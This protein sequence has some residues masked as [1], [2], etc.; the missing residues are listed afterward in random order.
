V[1]E[2]RFDVTAI[3][4]ALVDVIAEVDDAWVALHGLEKGTMLLVDPEAAER[5][6]GDLPPAIESSGGSAANTVAGIASLGGRAAYIGKVGDDQLG[7]V[8]AH[9]LRAA[10]VAFDVP[11]LASGPPTGRSLIAVTPDAQRTMQTLLGAAVE[12]GPEDVDETLIA[13]SAVTYLEGYLWDP[14]RAKEAFLKAARVAHHAGRR[15]A[16]TLSDRFC[17]DR[18]RQEFLDLVEH[19]VDVLFANEAE[20]TALYQ[21]HRFD[22]ALQHVVGHCEVAALTR[23]EKGAVILGAGEVHIV[24]AERIGPVVDTTGAGDLFAAGVLYGLTHGHDL[25]LSGQLGA[26][27]AAEVIGHYGARSERPLRDL[28]R[29]RLG[30]AI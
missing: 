26:L 11:A 18:H 9:D 8:F 3:G 7:R 21:V 30:I 5:I 24:D 10:G 14:P 28:V 6:Y 1:P 20:I 17:V 2:L 27:C 16:L 25:A 29:Q 12:L 22:D 4:N 19:H 13:S 23:S 15:V